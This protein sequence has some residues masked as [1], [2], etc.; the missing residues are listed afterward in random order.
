VGAGG[1]TLSFAFICPLGGVW[2]EIM[3]TVPKRDAT[4][5]R[6]RQMISGNLRVDCG[7]EGFILLG[8]RILD[9]AVEF[10]DN[11]T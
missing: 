3:I 5:N 6:M 4:V 11:R 9:W 1:D 7:F 8:A 2:P 10:N